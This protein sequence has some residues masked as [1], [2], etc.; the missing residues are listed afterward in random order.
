MFL[1]ENFSFL[2]L[3]MTSNIFCHAIKV[4]KYWK[5]KKSGQQN[6]L[7]KIT[8]F[9]KKGIHVVKTRWLYEVRYGNGFGS[10]LRKKK[11]WL[12][13]ICLFTNRKRSDL[14]PLFHVKGDEN[15]S[16]VFWGI[17]NAET[18]G[19]RFR[20]LSLRWKKIRLI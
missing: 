19:R 9:H 2:F 14:L 8:R 3:P 10:H 20:H 13:F 7:L 6:R 5:C 11:T 17:K 15:M 12:D 16:Y 1:R 4:M 18:L